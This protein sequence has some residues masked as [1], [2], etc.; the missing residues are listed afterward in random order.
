MKKIVT[1]AAMTA[2]VG[3]S[4][5][6]TSSP[7]NAWWR[8]GPGWG[9]RWGPFWGGVAAGVVVGRALTAPYYY[10]YGP[11]APYYGWGCRP[12]WNGYYWVR[13]CY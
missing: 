5:L 2:I 8:W 4:A 13:S 1:A 7:A 9:W 6:A 11:Y 10:P 12:W 3:L